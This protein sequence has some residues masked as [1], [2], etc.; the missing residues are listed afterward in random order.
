MARPHQS[1]NPFSSAW[2][3]ARTLIA[4]TVA[5]AMLLPLAGQGQ[6][7]APRSSTSATAPTP[8]PRLP[9]ELAKAVTDDESSIREALHHLED[10]ALI[11]AAMPKAEHV[12]QIRAGHQGDTW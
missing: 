6:Q 1:A 12:L 8:L 3:I 4:I 11:D 2:I 9:E 5:G 10:L 7:R